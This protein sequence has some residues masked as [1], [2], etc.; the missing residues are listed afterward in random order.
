MPA[1]SVSPTLL[2][3]NCITAKSHP[4]TEARRIFLLSPASVAGA[5]AA[6]LLRAS[7]ELEIADRLRRKGVPL[8]EL[9]SFV[10]SLYFRGKL[11]YASAFS[12][13]PPGINGS[14]V[15]TASSGLLSPDT[16]ITPDRLRRITASNLD[17][18]DARYRMPLDRDA[19]LLAER[20]DASCQ[21]I[22]LGSI[23]TAK[24]V[25]PL[26]SIFGAQLMFPAEFVGR[27]DMS[28]GGLM[29]RRV[30]SGEQL[31]YISVLGAARQG[32]RPPK[33][34]PLPR[35]TLVP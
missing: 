4:N 25:D 8:G 20:I 5:R 2:V 18:T 26:L 22:L 16:L 32:A 6:L 13:A 35:K 12:D 23:A 17:P 3:S 24:Y 10:S 14:F 31:T 15:I 30:E 9:F 34:K 19:R 28:R 29:L 11:A 21:V 1:Q 7:S 33:L 27:G